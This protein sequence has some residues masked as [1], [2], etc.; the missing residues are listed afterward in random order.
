MNLYLLLETQ[1]T[2]NNSLYDKKQDKHLNN[3]FHFKKINTVDNYWTWLN[4]RF[5]RNLRAQK[6]YNGDPPKDLSGFM[7]D[8]ANRLI[9]WAIMRQTRIKSELSSLS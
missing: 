5:V 2:Y 1:K 4:R 6:W 8:T 9:G 7:N 3:Y